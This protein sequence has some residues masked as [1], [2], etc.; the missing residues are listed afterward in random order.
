MM[1]LMQMEHPGL[2]ESYF[3]SSFIAEL[4]EGIKHY[5]IPHRPRHCV[6]HIG[7]LWSWKKT[8]SSKSHCYLHHNHS[9]NPQPHTP[10]HNLPSHHSYSNHYHCLNPQ[11]LTKTHNIPNKYPSKP[12]S[13]ESVGAV[14]SLFASKTQVRVQI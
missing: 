1:S 5:L 4:K 11:P 3:V 14:K 9:I 13:L 12:K 6:I 7:R 2:T 10:Q 8:F